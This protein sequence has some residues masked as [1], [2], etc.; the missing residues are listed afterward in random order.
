MQ[1]MG[2]DPYDAPLSYFVGK[3]DFWRSGVQSFHKV[4]AGMYI[5]VLI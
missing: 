3:Q 5:P 2:E 1:W 4:R